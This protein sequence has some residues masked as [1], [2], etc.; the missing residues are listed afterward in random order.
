LTAFRAGLEAAGAETA[1]VELPE[2]GQLADQGRGGHGPHARDSPHQGRLEGILGR[3]PKR[4]AELTVEL[5]DVNRD[6]G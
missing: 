1:P 5:G 4:L 6:A 2:L 3:G